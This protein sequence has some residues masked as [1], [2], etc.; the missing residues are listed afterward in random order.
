ME[1]ESSLRQAPQTSALSQPKAVGETTT[2]RLLAA[3]HLG[4]IA[5]KLRSLEVSGTNREQSSFE[6]VNGQLPEPLDVCADSRNLTP[7]DC[8]FA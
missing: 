4:L 2:L 3:D 7:T 6:Q 8:E 5:A 1:G